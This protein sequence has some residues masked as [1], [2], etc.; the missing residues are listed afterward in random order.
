MMQ[1]FKFHM[2]LVGLLTLSTLTGCGNASSPSGAKIATDETRVLSELPRGAVVFERPDGIYRQTLGERKPEL[3][4]RD[5]TY[6]RWSHDGKQVAFVRGRKIMRMD[7]AGGE[8]EALAEAGDP[9]AVA[10]MPGGDEILFT[11]GKKVR[12]VQL[13]TRAVRE[14]ASGYT[15][16]ELDV[17][18]D[19]RH[20]VATVR[21]L[22]PRI[23]VFDLATGKSRELSAG[24]S[25]SFSPD[26]QRVTRN[27]D[28][29]RAL[30]LVDTAGGKVTGAIHSPQ[31]TPFDNQFW[32]NHPD[33]VA[34]QTEGKITDILIHHI[35]TDRF[36]QITTSGD[37]GRPDLFINP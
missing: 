35:P 6:P 16:R 9:R 23:R 34:S 18:H 31:G 14:I 26:S 28:G 27:E 2:F 17:S 13:Q 8:P 19:G 7:A 29:H 1:T 4:A 37:V 36:A 5:A 12:G 20:M 30:S 15:F 25:A 3:L 22:G 33:W 10:W 11:D 32:S 21:G 24:C